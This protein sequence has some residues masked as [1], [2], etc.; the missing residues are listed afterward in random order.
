M[1]TKFS[2]HFLT[3]KVA[4]TKSFEV[5]ADTPA[6]A[7]APADKLAI[8]FGK[9]KKGVLRVQSDKTRK[10]IHESEDAAPKT[11]AVDVEA[12]LDQ[13]AEPDATPP[14]PTQAHQI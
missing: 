13:P 9:S 6:A 14:T 7:E 3:G 8:D 12:L 1:K 2:Y 5:E 11:K 10:Y 4:V